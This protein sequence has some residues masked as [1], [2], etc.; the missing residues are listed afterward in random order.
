MI[1]NDYLIYQEIQTTITQLHP[2]KL[3]F[4]HVDGHLD[5]KKPKCP[6]T[7]AETLNIDCDTRATQHFQSHPP[8]NNTHNPVLEHS[9]PHLHIGTQVIYR[10]I[11][12]VLRDA[13]TNQEYF[14]YL[15]EKFQWTNEQVQDIHWPSLQQAMRKLT[16]PERRIINK[17]IHKWLPLE[18]RYHVQ[19]LSEQQ[20]CPSCH[21][22]PETAKHFI[23]CTNPDRQQLWT[24][25]LSQ[26]QCL[27]FRYNIPPRIHAHLAQGLR[28][29]MTPN[30][31]A[32][33]QL[34]EQPAY[35]HHQNSLGWKPLLYGRYLS[36]WVTALHQ[37]TPPINGQ[38]F[39][40]KVIVLLM[41]TQILAIW[42]ICNHHQHPPT[43]VNTDRS[44]LRNLV[45]QIIYE[46]QQDT[47]LKALVGH[48]QID[49][50]MS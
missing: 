5:T 25:L 47:H 23:Q 16:K 48:I 41:W 43:T 9:Y 46:A 50:L 36:Q 29:S 40:T 26:V 24:D 8:L 45:Q 31:L 17:F 12:H 11:Q 15:Q 18:T 4:R 30:N 28:H 3:T 10:Q 33:T 38:H 49:Q 44:R 20:L 6:L 35:H 19:S 21:L 22:H 34:A 39:L 37:Q 42:S 27:S 13:A 2:I 14:T 1:A 7:I 32:T